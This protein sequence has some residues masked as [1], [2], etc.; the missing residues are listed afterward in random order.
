MVLHICP[1]CES[2]HEVH[3]ILDRLACGSQLTCSPRCKARFPALA[4]ARILANMAAN[5]IGKQNL[6]DEKAGRGL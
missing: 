5:E 1:V 6:A 4:R 2:R 3:P